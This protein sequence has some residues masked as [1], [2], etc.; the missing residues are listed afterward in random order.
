VALPL[1]G[2]AGGSAAPTAD[3]VAPSEVAFSLALL[4]DLS[5][6]SPSNLVLSPSS[7]EAALAM[8]A[9]GAKGD[10]EAG[11]LAALQ[12][13][14]MSAGTLASSFAAL[15]DALSSAKDV[16]LDESDALFAESGVTPRPA[17]VAALRAYFAATLHVVDFKTDPDGATRSVNA[18]V[19]SGTKGLIPVL[20]PSPLSRATTFLLADAIYLQA[21]WATPFRHD[22]TAP[23]TFHRAADSSM[24]V[25]FLHGSIPASFLER[26]GLTAVALPYAGGRLQALVLEPTSGSIGAFIVGLR[27][28]VLTSALAGLSHGSIDLSLPRLDLRS[29][30]S[31]NGPLEALGMASA[32]S[33]SA[34][35]SGIAAY[36]PLRVSLVRQ[37]A[38]LRVDEAGTTAAAA[39]GVGI[40][41]T[42]LP[43]NRAII[44]IDRPF[45]FLVR[46]VSTGAI[47][48]ESVVVQ[49]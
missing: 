45:V 33:N 49:P 2:A 27:P 21:R 29:G 26:P 23:G 36:P 18:F 42:A 6:S 19:D 28:S 40:I 37:A 13:G 11:I 20:F 14:S 9:L 44:D 39:T 24:T 15:R 5:G 43:A 41:A 47:V 8:V 34:D 48:F 31:L 10:T 1:V 7:L 25:P 4:R 38:T 17:Y 30:E 32:F 3:V 46:D 22:A 12:A 16:A 35:L